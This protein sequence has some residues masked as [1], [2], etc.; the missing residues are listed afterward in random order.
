MR[1]EKYEKKYLFLI[2]TEMESFMAH[3]FLSDALPCVAW[4]TRDGRPKP[5]RETKFS[6]T[7]GDRGI[8]I[9][10]LQ[11]STRRIGNLTYPVDPYSAIYADHTWYGAAG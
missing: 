3:F 10:S 11:L 5:S 1:Q 7:Y 4:L 2:C 8:S 6:G 9:F